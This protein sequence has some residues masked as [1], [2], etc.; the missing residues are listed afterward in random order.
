MAGGHFEEPVQRPVVF[1][2]FRHG[3]P[4]GLDP[5]GASRASRDEVLDDLPVLGL[6][7]SQGR[8]PLQHVVGRMGHMERGYGRRPARG[9]SSRNWNGGEQGSADLRIPEYTALCSKAGVLCLPGRRAGA[10]A[11]LGFPA[12]TFDLLRPGGTSKE[13]LLASFFLLPQGRETMC[14]VD[15]KDGQD[16]SV[17]QKSKNTDQ[18]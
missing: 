9:N 1:G 12:G 14:A 3:F 10:I 11:R 4:D 7:P 16:A 17:E 18:A 5:G 13:I 8:E 6:G 2:F 15:S